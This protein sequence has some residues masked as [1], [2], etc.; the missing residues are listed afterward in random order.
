[1]YRGGEQPDEIRRYRNAEWERIEQS[2]HEL[3]GEMLPSLR[4]WRGQPN[5]GT[6]LDVL[7]DKGK[8][9]L[10]EAGEGWVYYDPNRGDE[11]VE[12]CK[13][14]QAYRCPAFYVCTDQ[15]QVLKIVRLFIDRGS[16]E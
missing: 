13:S 10:R 9:V 6:A 8:Y 7:G 11:E 12:V 16:F 5:E 2:I 15:D 4:I 3:D 1:M 14:G